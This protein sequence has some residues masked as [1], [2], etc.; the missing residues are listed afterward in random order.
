MQNPLKKHFVYRIARMIIGFAIFAVGI[1]LTINANIGLGPWDV[2]HQGLSRTIGI[3]IGQASIGMGL[4]IVILDFFA[5]ERIGWGTLGNMLFIGLF[6]DFYMLNNLLPEQELFLAGV[7]QVMA[8]MFI[9]G[10]GSFLYIGVGLGC[11]P[12]DGLM[13]ALLKRT[14]RSVG[15]VRG[16]IEGVVL[17]FGWLLGGSVGLGT[18]IIAFLIGPMVQMAFRIVGFDV[19]NVQHSFID[20][21]IRALGRKIRH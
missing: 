5:G 12:R 3:T 4:I 7:I 6:I 16:S 20:E 21:D 14:N 17:F 13:V 2:F 1:V 15:V 9:I 10:I 19:K 11:G 8:G 18:L